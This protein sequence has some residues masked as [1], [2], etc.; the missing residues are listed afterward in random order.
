MELFTIHKAHSGVANKAFRLRKTNHKLRF[1]EVLHMIVLLIRTTI[2]YIFLLLTM[3]L[4]GKRQL[5]ELEISELVSTLLLSDIASLPITNQEIPLTY[6]IVPILTITAFEVCS[7]LLLTK[8][9]RLKYILS[10]RPS[11]VI[12]KGKINKSELL[13]NRI[14]VDELISELRQKSITD[15]S[16]VDYA[17][18]EQ[19]GK[20]TV[21]PKAEYMQPTCRDLG[22]KVTEHGLCHIIVS[23]GTINHYGLKVTQKDLAWLKSTLAKKKK[24]LNGIFLMTLDDSGDVC[25]IEKSQVLFNEEKEGAQK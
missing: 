11:V 6:A 7:S 8:V 18:I 5:G 1:K 10:T 2:I 24:C 14:S 16:Q 13:K 20:M 21:I 25:I 23:D 19:N 3:R 12:Q 15:I 4:M 9:P 17:I 22:L